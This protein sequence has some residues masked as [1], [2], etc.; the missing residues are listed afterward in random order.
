MGKTKDFF[1]F[2]LEQSKVKSNIVSKYFSAW[3][4]IMSVNNSRLNYIDLFSGPGIYDDGTESTPIK[5]LKKYK[6]ISKPNITVTFVFN[7]S[8]KV[9]I[10]NLEKSIQAKIEPFL[11]YPNYSFHYNN[12]EVVDG[13]AELYSKKNLCPSLVFIDPFGYKGVTKNL[14][15]S[16][17][18]DWGSDCFL[19]FNM[20]RIITSL[21]NPKVT[22]H[23]ELMF[24][25]DEYKSLC[26]TINTTQC[27]KETLIIDRYSNMLKNKGINYILP[28]RFKFHDKN[29]TSHYLIFMSKHKLGYKLCKEIMGNES[30]GE[31]NCVPT[32]EYCSQLNNQ[33]K[34][35][36]AFEYNLD[37]LKKDIYIKGLSE[38]KPILVS[39]IV[40]SYF[41]A[42]PYTTK[43]IK[44]V[45]SE[46]E[47]ENK[48]TVLG[49]KRKGTM[50]DHAS[51]TFH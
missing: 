5:I 11:P 36:L 38:N 31:G 39:E 49:R 1:I 34:F 45:L 41:Y 46:L 16:L 42:T 19:F 12:A 2:S 17:I 37:S 51:L 22:N 47:K 30:T 29:K 43:N 50:P 44:F 26:E 10:N 7:D 28:F 3:Y 8:D 6:E 23:M 27:D 32:F 25:A 15:T 40:D 4:K 9:C 33:L 21:Q 18:K 24:G 14:I 48:I 20:N 35:L 13:L